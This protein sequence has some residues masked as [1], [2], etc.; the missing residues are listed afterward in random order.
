MWVR[1][2]AIHSRRLLFSS[3]CGHSR[4]TLGSLRVFTSARVALHA[5]GSPS[6][7][8][9][10]ALGTGHG[11]G[12]AHAGHGHGLGPVGL[13]P[14]TEDDQAAYS[15][16]MPIVPPECLRVQQGLQTEGRNTS[17]GP[18]SF[19]AMFRDMSPY[20]NFHRGTTMVIHLPGQLVESN[21]FGAVMHDIAL[22]NTFGVK[23]VLVAGSRPQLNRQ[24]SLR[25]LSQRFDCGMRITGPME[26]Q[27]AMD[28]AGSVRFQIESY[29]GRGIVNSPGRAR[30]INI[31]SGNFITAQPVGVRGGVDFKNT[32]EMRR[33]NVDKVR[34]ALDD[35]DI[36]LISSIG[37]SAS[38]EVFNC[39][40]EQVASKCAIQLGSAKLIFLHNGEELIDSRSNSV[41]QTL[42]IEQ[43]QQYVELARQNPDISGDFLLYLKESIK[44]CVNGV[45]RSHLVSRHVDGGLLQELFTRDGEGLMITK[46]MYEGI[47]MATTNDIVSIMRL[48]QPLL[49]DDV[50]VSR[51]QE[52][53]ESNVDTFTVVERDGAII[54]CCTLQ[55]YENNFAEMGCV[56]VDSTYRN[57]G[58]GNAML[59][60]IMRKSAA[61]GVT[62][63]FVLTTRTAHWFLERGF[64]EATVNDLPPS[65][66]AKIDLRRKSKVYICDISTKKALDEKELLLQME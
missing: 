5:A 8:V 65:K 63:L 37:Y 24:L 19:T 42:V 61:M 15:D 18:S 48:I 12:F 20:I 28:A 56:A 11:H 34:T 1:P 43:A 58:K 44:A 64:V 9:N 57:L 16:F 31:A 14:P 22:L 6:V 35:G 53:I 29:L 55:P 36:V 51:D 17:V 46:H 3:A 49:D 10:E 26:L 60:Y 7:P 62:K 59:G 54:A 30:T 66:L 45:K 41:V 2:S 25:K 23:L 27:C 38:G 4:S 50:L 32:G 40:S 39:L 13:V 33:L 52:Q 47:R 21:L